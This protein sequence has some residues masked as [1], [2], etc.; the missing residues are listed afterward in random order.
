MKFPAKIKKSL[1][2]KNLLI[3]LKSIL[4]NQYKIIEEN[5]YGEYDDFILYIEYNEIKTALQISETRTE[6][7]MNY[8]PGGAFGI[9]VH[10][11]NNDGY[12]ADS[13]GNR[14]SPLY[15]YVSSEDAL[16]L[17][18]ARGRNLEDIENSL[19]ILKKYL[20][21]KEKMNNLS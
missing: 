10:L 12:N 2:Y 1:G 3:G 17:E 11:E 19:F 18:Y 7:M 21:N 13:K 6:G 9:D 5:Y 16:V 14:Y 8:G 4:K 15:S 20:D